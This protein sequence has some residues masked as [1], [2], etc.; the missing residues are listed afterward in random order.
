M[1]SVV[2]TFLYTYADF[3]WKHFILCTMYLD[4]ILGTLDIRQEYTLDGTPVHTYTLIQTHILSLFPT[5]THPHT[6]L[7]NPLPFFY[8]CYSRAALN[9]LYCDYVLCEKKRE[10]P[11][12]QFHFHRH[13]MASL[14]TWSEISISFATGNTFLALI[15]SP[16]T[17]WINGIRRSIWLHG[18][19]GDIIHI[20]SWQLTIIFTD[21]I[22][23][24]YNIHHWDG[25]SH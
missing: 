19:C 8:C 7:T 20:R 22:C 12:I 16:F 17:P 5:Y 9:Y 15:N 13:F 18:L 24:D 23:M 11:A 10:E 4:P 2:C 3:F 14:Q 1:F 6:Q 21:F 25:V